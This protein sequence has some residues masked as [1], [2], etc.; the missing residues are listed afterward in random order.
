[1][2]LPSFSWLLVILGLPY[3]CGPNT[4]FSASISTWPSSL[5][6]HLCL[7]VPKPPIPFSYKDTNCWIK[8]S[9]YSSMSRSQLDYIQKDGFQIRSHYSYQVRAWAY[10]LGN[11]LQPF[12]IAKGKHNLL[13]YKVG[14][15]LSRSRTHDF[16]RDIYELESNIPYTDEDTKPQQGE[17]TYTNP[18]PNRTNRIGSYVYLAPS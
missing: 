11:T 8:S 18:S 7:S 13:A 3:P 4:P 10:L 14:S 1:M 16:E 15:C 6:V 12:T 9:P 5:C 17:T 2:P